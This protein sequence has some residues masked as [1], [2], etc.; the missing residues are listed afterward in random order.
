MDWHGFRR[1]RKVVPQIL[2]ELEL[3]GGAQIKDRL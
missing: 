2:D 1:S 3:L